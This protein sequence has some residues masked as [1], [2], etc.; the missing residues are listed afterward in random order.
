MKC[1]R[2][3]FATQCSTVHF[4]AIRGCRC[5]TEARVIVILADHVIN[6]TIRC[7]IRITFSVLHLSCVTMAVPVYRARRSEARIQQMLWKVNYSDIVF[8]N[9]VC[10]T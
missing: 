2:R 10:V 9:T 4:I 6:H 3:F 1:R 8:V 5:T 7:L